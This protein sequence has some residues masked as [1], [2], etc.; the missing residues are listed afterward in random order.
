MEYTI[1]LDKHDAKV[2]MET[3]IRRERLVGENV[4]YYTEK[5]F[6]IKKDQKTMFYIANT[7][8]GRDEWYDLRRKKEHYKRRLSYF[9]REHH[10]I[11][12]LLDGIRKDKSLNTRF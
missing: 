5:I 4:A 12:R 10:K 11:C 6:E 1:T 2:L 7:Q 9:T 8:T 3:L